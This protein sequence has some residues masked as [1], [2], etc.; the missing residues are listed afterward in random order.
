MRPRT[1]GSE[2][3]AAGKA[4]RTL[5]LEIVGER[6]KGLAREVHIEENL[7]PA[8]A[9]AIAP[10]DGGRLVPYGE[11]ASDQLTHLVLRQADELGGIDRLGRLPFSFGGGEGTGGGSEAS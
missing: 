10:D 4:A 9:R 2:T 7:Q 11:G 5:R 3:G 1:Q 6:A 8:T